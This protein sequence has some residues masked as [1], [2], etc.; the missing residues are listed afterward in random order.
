MGPAP[1]PPV[2]RKR[3]LILMLVWH[4]A[5]F[6]SSQAS[7]VRADVNVK[8]AFKLCQLQQ[9]LGVVCSLG[10]ARDS[11]QEKKRSHATITA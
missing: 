4:F 11:E 1:T 7:D 6:L 10:L 5:R 9:V 2:L 3:A 8:R